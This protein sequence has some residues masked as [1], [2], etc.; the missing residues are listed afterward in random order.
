MMSDQNT[1][2]PEKSGE[3]LDQA[4]GGFAGQAGYT[5][6]FVDGRYVDQNTADAGDEEDRAGSYEDGY[7]APKRDDA[8]HGQ[9]PRDPVGK[10]EPSNNYTEGRERDAEGNEVVED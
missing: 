10:N 5:N 8:I 2:T 7:G 6:E 1:P 9:P 3:S 4:T